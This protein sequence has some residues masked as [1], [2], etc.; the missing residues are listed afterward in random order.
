[1][2][3]RTYLTSSQSPDIMKAEHVF[4]GKEKRKKRKKVPQKQDRRK[5]LDKL[6]PWSKHLGTVMKIK[7]EN[8]LLKW[9]S[10]LTS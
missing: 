6:Q 5:S 8:A 1:M 4:C 9:N 3:Y 10:E 7:S 2:Q